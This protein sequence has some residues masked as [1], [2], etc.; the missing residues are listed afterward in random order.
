MS[1]A[2][3]SDRP[4]HVQVAEVLGWTDL[5]H[6]PIEEFEEHDHWTGKPPEGWFGPASFVT[7]KVDPV[8]RLVVNAATIP[9]FHDD[10]AATW[11]LIEKYGLELGLERNDLCPTD[12]SGRRIAYGGHGKDGEPTL[13]GRGDTYLLAVCEVLLKMGKRGLL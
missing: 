4:L 10:P 12:T 13:E 6:I 8:E 3:V 7:T 1:Q 5:H 2:V 11:P 9:R